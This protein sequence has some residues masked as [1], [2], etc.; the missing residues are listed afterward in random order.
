M[1]DFSTNGMV[2]WVEIIGESSEQLIIEADR[3]EIPRDFLSGINDPFEIAR[4]EEL[5]G[6]MGQ[7]VLVMLHSMAAEVG[8]SGFPE[9]N[10]QAISFIHQGQQIITAA[11]RMPEILKPLFE[12]FHQ[13]I[14]ISYESLV[15]TSFWRIQADIVEGLRTVHQEITTMQKDIQKSSKNKELYRLIAID[16]SLASF[17]TA[18]QNNR[19]VLEDLLKA[20]RFNKAPELVTMMHDVLIESYQAESMV[21][22]GMRLVDLLNDI[23]SN[24]IS[25]NLNNIMKVLT[26]ITIVL[27]IPMV[28][29]GL[30]GMNVPVPF[31]EHPLGFLLILG[32]AL[33]LS[34]GVMVW[35]I[36]KEYL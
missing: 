31:S 23:F 27:T 5:E 1:T 19:N 9:Y 15:L 30:W 2:A 20:E 33:V 16:K 26:S 6:D 34:I 21:D 35:L 18:V 17:K 29:S 28:I 32:I 7:Q 4:M 25:N 14:D 8:P 22:E 24:V 10:S 11:Q 3:H 12:E 36:M 13:N